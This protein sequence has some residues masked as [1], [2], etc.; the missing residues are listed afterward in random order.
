MGEE[1]AAVVK[2]W[3]QFNEAFG[4]ILRFLGYAP[5]GTSVARDPVSAYLTW[6]TYAVPELYFSDD[7]AKKMRKLERTTKNEIE[8]PHRK[9]LNDLFREGQEAVIQASKSKR[10]LAERVREYLPGTA[11][12]E[13][14]RVYRGPPRVFAGRARY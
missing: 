3:K 7:L 11:A 12:T 1:K 6:C 8:R 2:A 9:F 5:L 10:T 4:R 14:C 13:E